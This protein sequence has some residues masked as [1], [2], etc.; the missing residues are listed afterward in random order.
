MPTLSEL[1]L[2]PGSEYDFSTDSSTVITSYTFGDWNGTS[3]NYTVFNSNNP[4]T[5]ATLVAPD[6]TV[7]Y[8]KW[9]NV[10]N[11]G[12][13]IL[14]DNGTNIDLGNN[15]G[16][17]FNVVPTFVAIDGTSVLVDGSSFLS[18]QGTGIVEF[19]NGG[20]S[21]ASGYSWSD[22]T[23]QC[24]S[25]VASAATQVRVTNN[26]GEQATIPVLSIT[27]PLVSQVIPFL[28]ALNLSVSATGLGSLNYSWYLNGSALPDTSSMYQKTNFGDSDRGTYEVVIT[29]NSSSKTSY[30][31]ISS[32]PTIVTQPVSQSVSLGDNI[33]LVVGAVGHSPITYQ[34]KFGGSSIPSATSSSYSINGFDDTN[35]GSYTVVVTADGSS[36]T[37]NP[38]VLNLYPAVISYIR[39]VIHPNDPM[40]IDGYSFG[41]LDGTVQ[42]QIDGT[43]TSM[44]ITSWSA[45]KIL[46]GSPSKAGIYNLKI[47]TEDT[48]AIYGSLRVGSAITGQSSGSSN[49]IG[50][51]GSFKTRFNWILDAQTLQP[52]GFTQDYTSA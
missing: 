7:S 31:V 47:L 35:V 37:S 32:L 23:I 12:K 52:V 29:D 30:A 14:A 27:S 8:S 46:C 17:R 4:P 16:I 45:D 43:W 11:I 13:T 24:V 3:S 51:A 50:P 1:V 15:S 49:Y 28:G 20:W 21:G 38:A 40:E 33:S 34:W 39:P 22:T 6:A 48:T 2:I 5:Q 26:Y 36:V 42:C 9:S 10:G 41:N 19:Y 44:A 18:S 25:A